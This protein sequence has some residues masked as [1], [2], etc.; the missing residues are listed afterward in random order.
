MNQICCS[1]GCCCCSSVNNNNINNIINNTDNIA[2]QSGIR[3][4]VVDA[5][6]IHNEKNV[7]PEPKE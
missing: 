2:F 1:N 7:N 6:T 4:N 5:I 3:M